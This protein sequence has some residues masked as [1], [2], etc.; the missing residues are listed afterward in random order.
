MKKNIGI[1]TVLTQCRCKRSEGAGTAL[2]ARPPRLTF[3]VPIIARRQ[4]CTQARPMR[5]ITASSAG[6]AKAARSHRP[7]ITRTQDQ[8][9]PVTPASRRL[10]Q[11]ASSLQRAG[12]ALAARPHRPFLMVTTLPVTRP[13]PRLPHSA[14]VLPMHRRAIAA[15]EDRSPR[16]APQ[17]ISPVT[18]PGTRLTQPARCAIAARTAMSCIFYRLL[19]SKSEAPVTPARRRLPL[20]APPPRP[21]HPQ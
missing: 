3:R 10:P 1:A 2:A 18:Q 14:P 20:P 4:T 7:L 15:L 12:T 17:V 11:P 13:R 8:H 9:R 16:V 6:T 19:A 5:R 21:H